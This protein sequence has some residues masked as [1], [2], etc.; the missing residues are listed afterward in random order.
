VRRLNSLLT[1]SKPKPIAISGIMK[2][3]ATTKDSGMRS[4]STVKMRRNRN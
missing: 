2:F 3:S 1:A 4:G